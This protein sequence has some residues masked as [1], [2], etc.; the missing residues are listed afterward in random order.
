MGM[1]KKLDVAQKKSVAEALVEKYFNQHD[2]IIRQGDP[3]NTFYILY[4]GVVSVTKDGT[5]LV[6]LDASDA[7]QFFGEGALLK[8]EPRAA[9][10]T[11]TSSHAKALAMDRH[12]FEL[13]LGQVHDQLAEQTVGRMM[14]LTIQVRNR[15]PSRGAALQGPKIKKADL[16]MIALLGC[17]GFGSVELWEHKSNGKVYALKTISKGFILM[18][19]A[20]KNV[21]NEKNIMMMLDSPFIVKLYLLQ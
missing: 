14:S 12:A 19:N 1:L 9:T 17:G 11:V 4:E 13:L 18:T 7:V 10:I 3:G 21:M 20:Q 8:N 6:S 16:S 5:A 15:R 2:V